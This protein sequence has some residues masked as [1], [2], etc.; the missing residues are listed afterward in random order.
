MHQ[1]KFSES[2]K[3]HI[4]IVIS[5]MMLT[6]VMEYVVDAWERSIGNLEK[7]DDIIRNKHRLIEQDN[8]G[9]ISQGNL[10]LISLCLTISLFLELSRSKLNLFNFIN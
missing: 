4:F 6:Y 9:G 7:F 3:F 5:E 10:A 1:Y 2:N 8:V